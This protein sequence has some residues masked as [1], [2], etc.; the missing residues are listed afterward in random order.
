MLCAHIDE[1][2]IAELVNSADFCGE[3]PMRTLE[4]GGGITEWSNEESMK[5]EHVGLALITCGADSYNSYKNAG[6]K[7]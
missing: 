5:R 2:Q 7:N 3:T 6:M 4:N 1:K